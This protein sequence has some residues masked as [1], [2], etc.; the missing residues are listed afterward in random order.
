MVTM[1]K[2]NRRREF[3]RLEDSSQSQLQTFRKSLFMFHLG[4]SMHATGAATALPL[5]KSY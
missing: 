2:S 1:R 3:M 4:R 5:W